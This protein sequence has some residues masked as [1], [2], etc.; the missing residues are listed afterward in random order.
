MDNKYNDNDDKVHF[1]IY[2]RYAIDYITYYDSY[3]KDNENDDRIIR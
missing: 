3:N 1:Y 2:Y